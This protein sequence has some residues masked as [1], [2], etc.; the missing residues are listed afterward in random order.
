MATRI[1]SQVR[2]R[3]I[4][5]LTR[6]ESVTEILAPLTKFGEVTVMT[7]D[8]N[9]IRPNKK[10]NFDIGVSYSYAPI[11]H[12]HLLDQMSFKI[13]N[14]HP[15]F[16]PFGRGIYPI[17]WAA[18]KGYPQGASIHQ[19]DGGIDTGPIY[20]R[21]EI[22]LD[23]SNTLEQCRAILISRAKFLLFYNFNSIIDGKLLPINQNA[24]GPPQQ[25]RSR[26]EGLQLLSK[27]PKKWETTL[28]EIQ[29]FVTK[30]Q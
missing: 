25:Y 30:I 26:N 15:T 19:I 4:L 16:L 3:R 2:V 13:V 23:D 12:R 10:F 9:E 14:V 8:L 11:I 24:F 27:F 29:E 1:R 22:L 20:A 5:L 21:E 18:V 6:Q 7:D 28:K 17:L